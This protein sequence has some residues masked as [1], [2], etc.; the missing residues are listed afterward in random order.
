MLKLIKGACLYA[1]EYMGI[2]DVLLGAGTILKI[3]EEI[4]IET[5]AGLEVIDGRGM[6]LFPGFIDCHVHITGGGGEGGFHTRTPEIMLTD[7]TMGGVTTVLGVLGTDGTMRT[8]T[9]LLAKARALEE[10]GITS[11]ITTGSYQIPV[12]T[13]TGSVTDDILLID[14]IIGVGEI[15]ISDHRSSQPT[16]EELA[17]LAAEARVAGMLAG[18]AGTITIHMGDSARMLDLIEAV[19]E[20]TEIPM[21]HFIPT[22]MNRNPKLFEKAK[23]YARQGGF[24]DF[25]TSTILQFIEEGEVPAWRTLKYLREEQIPLDGVTFS[26]DGQGS[27]PLFNDKGEMVGIDIGRVTTLYQA[28]RDAI[29]KD[30]VPIEEAVS[31]I[32]ANPARIYRLPK[33]G[34]IAP[35]GDADLVLADQ[36]TLEIDT[37][38]AKGQL[39][40]A[41]KKAVKKGTFE[42]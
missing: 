5:N 29:Q 40:V 15:A 24:V 27:L 17:K 9:N 41:Q 12:K 42:R 34:R 2:K 3:D 30:Q 21:K 36:K 22:H 31:V 13:L 39:L 7:L 20:R 26:S 1:P 28:V 32:T 10:E 18:K 19:L 38:I 6:Y 35:G 8:M 33:K 23:E 37:V 4:R 25:T 14:K 11:Y 16:F